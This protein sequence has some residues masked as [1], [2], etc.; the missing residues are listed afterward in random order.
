MAGTVGHQDFKIFGQIS[1]QRV[2]HLY[3]RAKIRFALCKQ[4]HQVL[5]GMLTTSKKQADVVVVNRHHP[6]Y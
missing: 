1:R 4:I 2:A 6:I 5:P 3:G